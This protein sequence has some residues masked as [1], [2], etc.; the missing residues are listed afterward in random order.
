MSPA[1][2]SLSLQEQVTSAFAHDLEI[3]QMQRLR[4][5]KSPAFTLAQMLRVLLLVRR[6]AR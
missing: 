6:F 4:G 1:L 3:I 5:K 2:K